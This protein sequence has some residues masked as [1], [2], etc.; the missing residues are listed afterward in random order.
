MKILCRFPVNKQTLKKPLSNV[1][2]PMERWKKITGGIL[3]VLLLLAIIVVVV[4]LN[5][6]LMLMNLS[7]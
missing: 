1:S 3:G 4:A 6:R 2:E 5:A 7:M